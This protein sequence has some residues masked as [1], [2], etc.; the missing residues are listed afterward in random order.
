M[1]RF[2][3]QEAGFLCTGRLVEIRSRFLSVGTMFGGHSQSMKARQDLFIGALR[4]M[5]KPHVIFFRA[6]WTLNICQTW[7]HLPMLSNNVALAN[8]LPR[9]LV[10]KM[11]IYLFP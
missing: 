1:R 10:A 11:A 3:G 6:Q 4:N 2:C 5:V 8:V 7:K 9:Q